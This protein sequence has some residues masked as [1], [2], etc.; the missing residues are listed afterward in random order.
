MGVG[1]NLLA[2]VT[3]NPVEAVITI[4]DRRAFSETQVKTNTTIRTSNGPDTKVAEALESVQTAVADAV[5]K[6]VGE[7]PTSE[8]NPNAAGTI[9]K[10]MKVQFNPSTITIQAIGGGKSQITNFAGDT[11]DKGTG[12]KSIS[13]STLQ[14]RITVTI[15]LIFDAE[16]NADAFLQDKLIMSPT[17]V[18]K[19]M[20]TAAATI[21]G[22]VEFSVQKQVE[23]LVAVLRNEYTREITFSWSEMS[24]KGLINGVNAQYTMFSPTGKPIRAVV[25]LTILC[26][27]TTIKQGDMGQWEDRYNDCFLNPTNIIKNA[28]AGQQVSSILNI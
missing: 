4:I 3:G 27:D 21:F 11:S 9:K 12:S 13:Y 26:V 28:K 18:L 5:V 25:N 15:P 14:P 22:G 7:L 16:N 23:G 10:S 19:N 8:Y 1:S 24:Y 17:S 20:A 2:S 6:T